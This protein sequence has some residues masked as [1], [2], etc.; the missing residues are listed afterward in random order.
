[1]FGGLSFLY[2]GKMTVGIVKD[3]L[4]V[5][6]IEPKMESEL[7]KAHV[8]PMDFTKRS[9]KEFVYV[10]QEGFKTEVQL[11]HYIELG[12]EHAKSKL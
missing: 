5:R 9:M 6:I 2:Q 10:S 3:D 4:A 12:L 8:R 7:A 11:L 1:M